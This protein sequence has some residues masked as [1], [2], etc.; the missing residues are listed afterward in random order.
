LIPVATFSVLPSP[1]STVYAPAIVKANKLEPCGKIGIN[2]AIF[3][4]EL[5]MVGMV[6]QSVGRIH[7]PL[8][9]G[10]FIKFLSYLFFLKKEDLREINGPTLLPYL[11]LIY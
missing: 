3:C 7:P 9:I 10:F 5:V 4:S 11:A 8:V 1:Q 2:N 6:N